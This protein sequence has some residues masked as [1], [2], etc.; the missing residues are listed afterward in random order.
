MLRIEIN[1]DWCEK[2]INWECIMKVS[3]SNMALDPV[4]IDIVV[5][6]SFATTAW[7]DR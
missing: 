4:K 2:E 3:L 6:S 5:N 7:E 1:G